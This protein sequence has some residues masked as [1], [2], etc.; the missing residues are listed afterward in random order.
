MSKNIDLI[1]NK[2]YNTVNN[3]RDLAM[4]KKSI[5]SE[6]EIAFK[7]AIAHLKGH[8]LV[9]EDFIEKMT[10]DSSLK[11]LQMITESSV[12]TRR[13]FVN[14]YFLD[15]SI[16]QLLRFAGYKQRIIVRCDWNRDQIIFFVTI[17]DTPYRFRINPCYGVRDLIGVVNFILILEKAKKLY[18]RWL[19][20]D[21]WRDPNPLEYFP[22]RSNI[23]CNLVTLLDSESLYEHETITGENPKFRTVAIWVKLPLNSKN[24]PLIALNYQLRSDYNLR[25]C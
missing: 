13:S 21:L 11:E 17:P 15:E 4:F 7:R 25:P 9:S 8:I 10:E 19:G 24:L 14:E 16:C 22:K 6:K 5:V 3:S 2:S 1:I 20:K 23:G 12:I 18:I